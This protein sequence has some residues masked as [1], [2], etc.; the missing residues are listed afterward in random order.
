M[1][2][3]EDQVF[4]SFC[5]WTV[6]IYGPHCAPLYCSIFHSIFRHCVTPEQM[7]YL[8]SI[9]TLESGNFFKEQK[10]H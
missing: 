10:D 5:Q 4:A 9:P 6:N 7:H 2:G 1:R 8:S 3:G